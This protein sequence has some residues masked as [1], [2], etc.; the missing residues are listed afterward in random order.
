MRNVLIAVV[1][2][3]GPDSPI[4]LYHQLRCLTDYQA[5]A[6]CQ[7]QVER[8]PC[9]FK[10]S[11]TVLEQLINQHKPSHL[12]LLSQ[13]SSQVDI[14]VEKVALNINDAKQ[15][16]NINQ[17]PRDTLTAQHGPAAY[18]SNLPVNAITDKLR[19]NNL[20]VQLSYN[21]GTFVANHLFYGLMH[22]IKHQNI[23]L[24]GGLL[25]FPLLPQQAC[26]QPGTASISIDVILNAV[27][28]AADVCLAHSDNMLR[29]TS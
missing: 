26:L 23:S 18:F 15:N 20:P 25:Q 27:K 6:E 11:L 21:A 19:S 28:L 5:D 14:R 1:D 9:A 2:S 29:S 12:M 17:Q 7:L 3:V 13:C 4:A 8:L 24:H 22:Y 16:D 10:D